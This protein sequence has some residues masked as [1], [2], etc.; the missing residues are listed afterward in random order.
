[1]SYRYLR[2]SHGAACALMTVV[3]LGLVGLARAD[4]KVSLRLDWVNSGYHA[5][6]YYG[7]DKG[8]FKADGI[9]LEVLEG[10]G[11]ATT[12]QTV[13]NGSTQFGTVDAGTAMGLVAQGLP[14]KIVGGYLRQSPM[15]IIFPK[16]NGWTKIQDM[17]GARLGY[18]PGGASAQLLT[19]VLKATGMEGKINKINME[20]SAKPTALLE[21]KVDAVETFDFLYVPLFEANNLPVSTF[22][23]ASI[24]INVPGLALVAGNDLI[25]KNPALV[26]KVVGLMEK[27]LAAARKDPEG[28]ID[29]LMKRAPTLQRPVATRVLVL[30]FSLLDP[31]WSKGHASAWLSPEVM[32][33]AQDVLLQYGGLKEKRP[34]GDYFTNEFVAGN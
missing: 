25:A 2:V 15:A 20:G 32:E 19:P 17:A 1:M 22:T 27:T 21:G 6:W 5:I 3:L 12:A 23:Y 33:H 13:A 14:L 7:L 30:S 16:K 8:L 11:S 31:D 24:G 9:D 4:E 26:K 18:S 10:R 34:I 28:A 29:S